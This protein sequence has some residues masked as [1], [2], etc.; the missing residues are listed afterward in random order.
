MPVSFLTQE[1]RERFGRYVDEPTHEDLGRYFYLNDY[2]LSVINSLRGKHNRLGY[3][4]QLTTL[5]YLGTFPDNFSTIPDVVIQTLSHQLEI[6]NSDH[7]R[8]YVKSR[9]H[10]RHAAEIQDRYAYF[11]FTDPRVGLRLARWLYAHCWTG[12]DRPGELFKR[13]TAWLLENKVLLPG[14]T[15]LERFIMQLR[16]RVEKHLWRTLARNV[17]PEQKHRLLEL[18]TSAEGERSSRLEKLRSGPVRVSGPGLISNARYKSTG[19]QPV[20]FQQFFVF[21]M[22]RL[23]AVRCQ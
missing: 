1:Q 7:M 16:S 17:T 19:F 6:S 14:V 12:T 18:L 3:A 21:G 4:V 23:E 15:V 8:R 11:M 9:G 5:R 13:A 2:D 20:S 10:E 22:L